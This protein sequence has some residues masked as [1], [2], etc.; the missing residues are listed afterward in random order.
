MATKTFKTLVVSEEKL[1]DRIKIL[2]SR[3]MEQFLYNSPVHCPGTMTN[4]NCGICLSVNCDTKHGRESESE[5]LESTVTASTTHAL[6]STLFRL[7]KIWDKTVYG[8]I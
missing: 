7:K 8:E 5:Y 6:I 3:F 2:C 1:P 4:R